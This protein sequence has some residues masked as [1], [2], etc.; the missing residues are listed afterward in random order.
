ME[1]DQVADLMKEA[2]A[3]VRAVL[4]FG[5]GCPGEF[6]YRITEGV[7]ASTRNDA[8][9]RKLRARI[10]LGDLFAPGLAAIKELLEVEF[11][12]EAAFVYSALEATRS[13]EHVSAIS[14]QSSGEELWVTIVNA[15]GGVLTLEAHKFV[16]LLEASGKSRRLH[17][18]TWQDARNPEI[19]FVFN[20]QTEGEVIGRF[21]P[22]SGCLHV[23]CCLEKGKSTACRTR[24]ILD[25]DY[26]LCLYLVLKRLR[27][28]RERFARLL[29]VA[30]ATPAIDP[31]EAFTTY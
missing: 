20:N 1:T 12:E 8:L 28:D 31:F 2:L 4:G 17:E 13:R 26:L 3:P 23:A 15:G 30:D 21:D 9:R 11:P 6:S 25:L 24:F 5:S 22:H 14:V 19:H 27:A 29:E 10:P 16:G 7:L 18:I